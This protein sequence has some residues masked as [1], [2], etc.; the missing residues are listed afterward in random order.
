[1]RVIINA[2]DFGFSKGVNLGI[3]ESFENGVVTDTS[4][5]CNMPCFDHAI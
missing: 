3:L 2:D 5:M 4:L 1:M